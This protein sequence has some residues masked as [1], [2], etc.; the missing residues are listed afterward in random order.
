MNMVQLNE[1]TSCRRVSAD[2]EPMFPD[3]IF[4][5]SAVEF[6][7]GR[8]GVGALVIIVLSHCRPLDDVIFVVFD[9]RRS[10]RR[11]GWRWCQRSF[12]QCQQCISVCSVFRQ[13]LLPWRDEVD[14]GGCTWGGDAFVNSGA[15]SACAAASHAWR[16]GPVKRGE[17]RAIFKIC[18]L[19]G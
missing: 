19:R 12:S 6:G 18:F 14:G 10:R 13:L 1:F 2:E 15:A 16:K 8:T 4:K 17:N 3:E 5:L 7:D 9:F 11:R